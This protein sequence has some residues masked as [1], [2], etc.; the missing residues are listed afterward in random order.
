MGMPI[1]SLSAAGAAADAGGGASGTGAAAGARAA[2]GAGGFFA[3]GAAACAEVAAG[4]RGAAAAF[5][6]GVAWRVAAGDGSGFMMLTGGVDEALGNSALVGLP[7]GTDGGI[8]ASA[9]VTGIAVAA[10]GVFQ[11]GA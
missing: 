8:P 9:A 6:A 5:A 3:A 4:A 7:V 1:Y 2:F 10:A 11:V